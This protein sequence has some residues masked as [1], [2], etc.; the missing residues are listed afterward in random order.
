MEDVWTEHSD[1]HVPWMSEQV[2][3]FHMDWNPG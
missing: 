3:Y 1:V 2:Q